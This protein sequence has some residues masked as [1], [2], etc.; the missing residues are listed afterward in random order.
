MS[1]QK[2]S[3]VRRLKATLRG[4]VQGVGFRP[5]VYR[6]AN[7]L[8]LKGRIANTPQGVVLEVEGPFHELRAFLS[9]VAAEKHPRSF[10]E[11]IETSYLDPKGYQNFEID[12]SQQSGQRSAVI[13]PDIA[14]CEE[15]L[16]EIFDASNRRYYY[17]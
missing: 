15:C 16:R 17:P 1:L 2:N 13:L 9:R 14:T 6:L 10:I 11:S 8:D 7:E 3:E 12:E 5:F 4:A